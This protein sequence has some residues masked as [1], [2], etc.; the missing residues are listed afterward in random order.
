MP[1]ALRTPWQVMG[2]TVPGSTHVRAGRL[3]Q[4]A[5]KWLP[6]SGEGP[7]IILAVSDGHGSAKS[8]RS[9]IGA[10]F[11]VDTAVAV[12]SDLLRDESMTSNLTYA[13]HIIEERVPQELVRRWTDKV[14]NHIK[15]NRFCTDDMTIRAQKE[16]EDANPTARL[17]RRLVVYGA[18]L[19]V[20][21]VTETYVAYLQLGDGDIILVSEAGQTERPLPKDDKLF[22]NE[23]TS[24]CLPNAWQEVR[25][26]FRPLAS[27]M[28][29]L[30]L[31]SSDGYINSFS[32]QQGFLQ[33]G[34]DILDM[35]RSDGIDTVKSSLKGW[36]TEATQSGSGDD[37]TLGIVY[38]VGAVTEACEIQVPAVEIAP[39]VD[40]GP[41]AENNPATVS[42]ESG[43]VSLA[44]DA[45]S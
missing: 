28:P 24:L 17:D 3:S 38:R 37:I 27:A 10:Q 14:E 36:L 29:A 22:A 18:T 8:F 32:N 15:E 23:T 13:K 31:L 33:V 12:L 44:S 30:V 4:D 16:E 25:F 34:P 43:R 20:C 45:G 9:E 6:D 26:A 2:A 39:P 11:A 41:P 7:P 42:S 19:L 35:M 21:V 5:L 40:T 1:D